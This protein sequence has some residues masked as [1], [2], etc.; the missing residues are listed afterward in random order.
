MNGG[1]EG[2]AELID[3]EVGVVTAV[4]HAGA[5]EVA[6]CGRD[7]VGIKCA[8]RFLGEMPVFGTALCTRCEVLLV[9]CVEGIIPFVETDA[10]PG[11]GG[12][13]LVFVD[14]AAG[15]ADGA[16]LHASAVGH[17]FDECLIDFEG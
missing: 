3:A 13:L 14:L 16:M 4:D 17:L 8:Q 1:E 6:G 12:D 2:G 10:S 5:D 9:A 7:D 15:L 11:A